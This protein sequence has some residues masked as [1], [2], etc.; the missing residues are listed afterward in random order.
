MAFIS[1]YSFDVPRS[2]AAARSRLE[3]SGRKVVR[4]SSQ[5]RS[6]VVASPPG[7]LSEM[8]AP[9]AQERVRVTGW[10]RPSTVHC[11]ATTV[12]PAAWR[13]R[14]PSS[15]IFGRPAQRRD[16]PVRRVSSP[17]AK[18]DLPEPLRPRTTVSPGPGV[19]SRWAVGPT[20]RK[21]VTEMRWR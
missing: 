20:P 12:G 6:A 2:R 7:L 19:R 1:S 16:V 13:Q 10:S 18:L 21:P 9:G 8:A 14:Q 3:R 5:P 11:A 17:S 4:A 15:Q